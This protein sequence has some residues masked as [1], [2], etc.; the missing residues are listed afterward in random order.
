MLVLLGASPAE[1][2]AEPDGFASYARMAAATTL[3]AWRVNNNNNK[4]TNPRR[5]IASY[6]L[7]LEVEGCCTMDTTNMDDDDDDDDI[8]SPQPELHDERQPL[9]DPPTSLL[10]QFYDELMINNTKHSEDDNILRTR[11]YK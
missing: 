10:H 8:P 3:L 7:E 4:A 9:P 1:V 6:P 5:N 11:Q 2:A